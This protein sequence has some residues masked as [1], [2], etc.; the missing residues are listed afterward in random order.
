METVFERGRRVFFRRHCGS[1][2]RGAGGEITPPAKKD[3]PSGSLKKWRR[4]LITGVPR[5]VC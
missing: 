3:A 5:P 4:G 1:T 2:K